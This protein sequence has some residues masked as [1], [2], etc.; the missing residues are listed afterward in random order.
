[1]FSVCY[2]MQLLSALE[3]LHG[4]GLNYHSLSSDNILLWS[5]NPVSIKLSDAGITHSA[6]GCEVGGD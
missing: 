6:S 3:Y 4:Q 1:M 5:L 2:I